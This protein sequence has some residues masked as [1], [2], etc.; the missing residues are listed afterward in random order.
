MLD[1]ADGGFLS[2]P[3]PRPCA[4]EV[5]NSDVGRRA[6]PFDRI[7]RA[8]RGDLRTAFVADNALRSSL[9]DV[10]N[11]AHQRI[12]FHDRPG[13]LQECERPDTVAACGFDSRCDE[14]GAAELIAVEREPGERQCRLRVPLRFGKRAG[15]LPDDGERKIRP[16]LL[17]VELMPLRELERLARVG[18]RAREVTR[19]RRVTERRLNENL[20]AIAG[21]RFWKRAKRGI[22]AREMR[23]RVAG[24]AEF[25]FLRSKFDER[26]REQSRLRWTHR[27][28]RHRIDRASRDL[29]CRRILALAIGQIRLRHR[30]FEC[31]RRRRAFE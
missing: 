30:R 31:G 22:G 24:L 4:R 23:E 21:R 20:A 28:S 13:F 16:D 29:D 1:V 12:A 27:T 9:A 19:R 14:V 18:D 10:I 8:R 11:S 7:D 6:I 25:E 2:R 17:V 3:A 5:G 15:A 26:L